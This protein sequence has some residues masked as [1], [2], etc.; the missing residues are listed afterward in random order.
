MIQELKRCFKLLR[1]AYKLRNNVWLSILIFIVALLCIFNGSFMRMTGYVLS[2]VCM[3]SSLVLVV[4]LKD[5]YLF[6]GIVMASGRKRCL[7]IGL[8]DLLMAIAGVSSYLLYGLLIFFLRNSEAY[9]N[10]PLASIFIIGGASIMTIIV[11][12]SFAN[13][14]YVLSLILMMMGYFVL[15]AMSSHL[16]LHR[17]SGLVGH[18]MGYG[19]LAGAALVAVGLLLSMGIRRLLYRK[20]ASLLIGSGGLRKAMQ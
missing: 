15:G 1:Y 13:R 11:Y 10:V 6:S 9:E 20:P 19:F 18:N 12:Y 2:A 7:E 16:F 14:Y 8:T 4:Q 17:L 5:N 3:F